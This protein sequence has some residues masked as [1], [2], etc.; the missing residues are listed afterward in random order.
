MVLT[1]EPAAVVP[2][3]GCNPDVRE[4]GVRARRVPPIG[5]SFFRGEHQPVVGE[6][7]I[8]RVGQQKPSIGGRV[9][10]HEHG[11]ALA[12]RQDAALFTIAASDVGPAD[13][14]VTLFADV[15]HGH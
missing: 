8:R 10:Q 13:E 7:V 3:D 11:H 15:G 6:R 14:L 5:T 1:C 2:L 12:I 4:I 9:D